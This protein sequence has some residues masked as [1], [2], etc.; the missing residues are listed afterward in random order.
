MEGEAIQMPGPLEAA[1][2]KAE[3]RLLGWMLAWSALGSVA[4]LIG[5]GTRGA[6]GF[7]LGAALAILNYLWLHQAIVALMDAGRVRVP[8]RVLVKF[9]LRFPLAIAGLYGLHKTGWLLFSGILA[10]LFVP[11][12]GIL[13]EAGI[14]IAG[15]LRTSA[16]S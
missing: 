4:S 9:I 12:G 1:T 2:S 16:H 14:Q 15:G 6:G 10:G 5:W 11:V 8:K 7:A 13:V 3:A